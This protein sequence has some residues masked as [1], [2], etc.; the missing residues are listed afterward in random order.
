MKL[1]L[2]VLLQFNLFSLAS[3]DFQVSYIINKS[4]TINP[5]MVGR[6]INFKY[7]LISMSLY[8]NFKFKVKICKF[9]SENENGNTSK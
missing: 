5:D 3:N 2:Y 7:K 8:E 4:N 9:K 6:D 1:L